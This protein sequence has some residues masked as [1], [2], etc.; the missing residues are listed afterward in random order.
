MRAEIVE[1]IA[2]RAGPN[3]MMIRNFAAE[4]GL[5]N[6]RLDEIAKHAPTL[7]ARVLVDPGLVA[8]VLLVA[9]YLAAHATI[10]P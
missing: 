1:N 9:F 5:E 7:S 2:R 3:A 4:P 10:P 8:L 6:L